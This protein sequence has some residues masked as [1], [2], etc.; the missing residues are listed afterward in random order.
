MLLLHRFVFSSC[1]IRLIKKKPNQQK[2]PKASTTLLRVDLSVKWRGSDY[3]WLICFEGKTVYVIVSREL[4]AIGHLA[5]WKII[6]IAEGLR[7]NSAQH[8]DCTL[9]CC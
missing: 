8:F 9:A 7:G 5:G 1:I 2:H 3:L 6:C 4:D